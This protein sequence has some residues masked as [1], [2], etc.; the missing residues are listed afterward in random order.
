MVHRWLTNGGDRRSAEADQHYKMMLKPSRQ[1]TDPAGSAA[2]NQVDNVNLL[3]TPGGTDQAG[4]DGA[5]MVDQRRLQAVENRA[6]RGRR[7]SSH[8]WESG[9]DR[10][11]WHL[12]WCS[13]PTQRAEPPALM[14]A[15]PLYFR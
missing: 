2:S 12:A 13:A 7:R 4:R 14:P 1:G 5:P 3:K 9:R 10:R 11:R 15:A 6:R 8:R